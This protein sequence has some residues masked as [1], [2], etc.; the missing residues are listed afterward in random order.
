MTCFYVRVK[1]FDLRDFSRSFTPGRN[2]TQ[3]TF[4][5]NENFIWTHFDS[6][7]GNCFLRCQ[8]QLREGK[9]MHRNTFDLVVCCSE[10]FN[11]TT[12]VCMHA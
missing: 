10:S 9:N 8:G 4:Y 12:Y 11:C 2:I 5:F 3:A 1:Q 7:T 6:L